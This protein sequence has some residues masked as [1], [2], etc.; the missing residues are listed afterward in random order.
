ML[1]G[2]PEIMPAEQ[3]YQDLAYYIANVI[4]DGIDLRPPTEIADIDKVVQYGFDKKQ[5]FRHRKW[6]T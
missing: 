5:S 3:L 6:M 4:E 2:F 1:T